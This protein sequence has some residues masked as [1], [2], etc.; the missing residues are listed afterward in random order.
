V[1]IRQPEA[2]G[3]GHAVLCA[4]SLVGDETFA[5]ILADDLIDAQTPV[6]KQMVGMFDQY[7]SSI[8]GVQQVPREETRQYGIVA[9]EP[10]G[11]RLHKLNGIVEKPEPEQAPST[12]G[13][14]GRYILKPRIFSH[15]ERVSA[16]AGGEIQL[17]DAIASLIDEERILAYEFRGTRY[18]CGTKLGYLQATVALGRKHQEVGEAFSAF[19]DSQKQ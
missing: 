6:M 2:L 8:I 15:L 16:G 18:D 19:M 5:V 12:L 17:T 10:Y 14:V 3:L 4:K 13:V 9:S 7:H 1:Y 11:E